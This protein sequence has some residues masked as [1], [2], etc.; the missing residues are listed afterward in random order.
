MAEFANYIWRDPSTNIIR[1]IGWTSCVDIRPYKH[2]K[3][4][5]NIELDRMLKK[6]LREGF[7]PQPEIY[8]CAIQSANYAKLIE[9]CWIEKYGRKDLGNGTL[10]N[11]TDGGDGAYGCLNA[12]RPVGTKWSDEERKL[13]EEYF[14]SSDCKEKCSK[15]GKKGKGRSISQEQK[16]YLRLLKDGKEWTPAQRLAGDIAAAKRKG[17]TFSEERM[18]AHMLGCQKAIGSKRIRLSCL[19]CK[20][21]CAV[22]TF[23]AFHQGCTN[24]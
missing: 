11:Y 16:D 12:G 4:S 19:G 3:K 21:E 13:R 17:S 24:G 2:L 18:V 15:G 10:F 6:R 5:Q 7:D 8:I 1:Y 9:C 22:N 23:A 14:Q 20:K